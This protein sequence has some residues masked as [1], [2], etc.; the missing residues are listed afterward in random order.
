MSK[1]QGFDQSKDNPGMQTGLIGQRSV[2]VLPPE[3]MV[4]GSFLLLER[5]EVESSPAS[6]N[7]GQNRFR[8][9]LA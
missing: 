2:V 5:R 1:P 3:P 9:F 8:D 4:P 7:V 6:K